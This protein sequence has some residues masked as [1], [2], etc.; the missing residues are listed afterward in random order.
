MDCSEAR[1]AM[2]EALDG[3]LDESASGGLE[4]HFAECQLCGREWQEALALDR[5]ARSLKPVQPTVGFTERV[6]A[7]VAEER[8]QEVA[9]NDF[10][11]VAIIAAAIAAAVAFPLF[12]AGTQ[13]VDG[14]MEWAAGAVAQTS[15]AVFGDLS[16]MWEDIVAEI[17]SV[18]ELLA[19]P[20]TYMSPTLTTLIGAAALVVMV[21]FNY[22]QARAIASKM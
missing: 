9:V 16:A 20:M 13:T 18:R 7:R 17:T 14:W 5:L 15:D 3:D 4:E 2:D 12:F 21:V 8:P 1:R 19:Q 10:D 11:I 6:M 22:V